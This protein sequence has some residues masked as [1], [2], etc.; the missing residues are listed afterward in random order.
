M[1]IALQSGDEFSVS[2]K[3]TALVAEQM[4]AAVDAGNGELDHSAILLQLE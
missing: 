2:L 1:G 3:A 4:K